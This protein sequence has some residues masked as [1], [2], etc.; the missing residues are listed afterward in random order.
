MTETRVV[1]FTPL[2]SCGALVEATYPTASAAAAA[3][4]AHRRDPTRDLRVP[5]DPAL[6]IRREVVPR[7]RPCLGPGRDGDGC[8]AVIL[9][10]AS[11]RLCRLCT[12]RSAQDEVAVDLGE[13]ASV[14]KVQITGARPRRRAVFRASRR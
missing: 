6:V 9:T 10:V 12:M 14:R 13:A 1:G 4:T 11:H 7:L 2:C 3:A 8:D 5:H